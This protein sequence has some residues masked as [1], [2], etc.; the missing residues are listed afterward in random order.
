M[1]EATE[2]AS[3]TGASARPALLVGAG[4]FLS[5]VAGFVREAVFAYYFG[6]SAVGDVWRA[7]L[8]T[9]N[10]IQ[11]LLGEG[12]LS[13]SFI[14][15]YAAFLEEG[16][17]EEAG[18]FAGA[19]LGILATVSFGL[20]VVGILVAPPL[21]RTLFPRWEP[22]MQDLGIQLVRILFP[23][24]AVLAVT[25]WALGVL[26]SHRRFFLSY[27]APVAWN[28]ALITTMLVF[29]T[30]LGWN[31]QGRDTDLVV[32]LAWGGLAG[33]VLQLLVQL[34]GVIGVLHHFRLSV[35]RRVAG[36]QEAIRNF[37]PVVTARGVVNLSG[38]VDTILAGLLAVGAINVFG[39]ATTLYVLP[40]S[41]FGMSLAASELP[42]LSR[43]RDHPEEV[44]VPRVRAALERTAFLLIP[45][46]LAYLVLGDVFVAALFQRGAFSL[47]DTAVVYVVLACFSLGLQA[48]ASSR[49]LSSAFY[50]L[51]DTKTP[52]RAAYVRVGVSVGLGA[53][54]MFPLDRFAVGT[55]HLGAAGLALA[56][57]VA[58]WIEN[59]L[60]RRSL[61]GSLGS[62]TPLKKRLFKMVAAGVVAA[63]AAVGAKLLLGSAAPYHA[64]L[65]VAVLGPGSWLVWP[66]VAAGTAVVFG[67]SYLG[68]ASALGIGATTIR[69][70][71]RRR[72]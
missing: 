29:G 56:T 55:Q 32:A 72:G 19:A 54:L 68:V 2:A 70:L 28:L 15:V 10:V 39:Y 67:V 3:P 62:F 9:P 23:M 44:L 41:L 17:E 11:N 65:L 71:L 8:R 12:T 43:R 25:A 33:A 48:S 26:N 69:S 51:R 5:R 37:V 6:T 52:A 13:A 4:I 1:S 27:V 47:E 21:I 24:T 31:A 63:G 7:A 36:V 57:A 14:P 45:S 18:R 66:A 35:S 46:T 30:V 61:R 34:P 16:R 60:L 64:G 38:W 40:I 42:E 59:I 22:W 50:A 20:A 53:A 58:A 49:V